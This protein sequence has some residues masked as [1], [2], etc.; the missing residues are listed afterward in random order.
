[1]SENRK[2]SRQDSVIVHNSV[3]VHI[4]KPERSS[5]HPCVVGRHRWAWLTSGGQA[6]G[7]CGKR[8]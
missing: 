3:I 8:R 4:D 1:M 5:S 7:Y 2:E 6:C